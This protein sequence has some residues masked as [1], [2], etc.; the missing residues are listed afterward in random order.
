MSRVH[1]LVRVRACEPVTQRQALHV[2]L[3]YESVW[4]Y[5]ACDLMRPTSFCRRNCLNKRKK[6]VAV[7]IKRMK[8]T[9][10]V[11]GFDYTWRACFLIIF[12]VWPHI[13]E[14]SINLA[15]RLDWYRAQSYPYNTSS[16]P[17]ATNSKSEH[18]LTNWLRRNPSDNRVRVSNGVAMNRCLDN[19]IIINK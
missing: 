17:I 9:A 14:G 4:M 5:S 18:R 7:M 16:D 6:P 19:H 15:T 2:M 8:L 10:R 3:P 1:P 13:L 11:S 12:G